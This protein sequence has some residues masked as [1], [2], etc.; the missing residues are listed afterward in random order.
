MD[1]LVLKSNEYISV[2]SVFLGG[3]SSLLEILFI[4]CVQYV[5]GFYICI[6]RK[7][8]PAQNSRYDILQMVIFHM[9]QM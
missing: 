6:Q 5:L 9:K 3:H 7:F 4:M 8:C 1:K 2:W